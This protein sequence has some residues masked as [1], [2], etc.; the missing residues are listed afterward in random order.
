MIQRSRHAA[1]VRVGSNGDTAQLQRHALGQ[2][3]VDG[4]KREQY[5]QD[6]VHDHPETLPMT[7]IEPAFSPLISVCQE[8]PTRAGFVDNVWLTPDGGLV[9]GECKLM[10]NPQA[11]REVVAQVL[12]YAR[13]I[14]GWTF[15]DLQGAVAKAKKLKDGAATSLF[16]LVAG[17]TDLEEAQFVDAVQ[18]RL[19]TGRVLLLIIGDGIQEGVEALTEHLQMHAGIHAGMALVDLSVWSDPAGGLLIVPRVPMRTV[20]IERGIVTVDAAAG[21]LVQAPTATVI[22]RPRPVTASEP[23][24]YEQVQARR[25]ELV[26]PLRDFLRSMGDIDV[27]PVFRKAVVLRFSPSSDVEASAGYIERGGAFHSADA[28]FSAQKLGR[29]EAGDAYLQAMAAIIGGKVTSKPDAKWPSLVGP[30]GKLPDLA[31]LLK[32][33]DEW[34]QAIRQLVE[35]LKVD[36]A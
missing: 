4:G 35:A 21:L 25:P 6:L 17:S 31:P 30:D 36:E 27:E 18:R 1:P 3:N 24:F 22:D 28:W 10:R 33:S 19:R 12:D 11:R 2:S 5:I 15:E 32:K 34:R 7:E 8:L 16:S 29:V 20:V 23:E 9:L 14:I 13:A 26:T